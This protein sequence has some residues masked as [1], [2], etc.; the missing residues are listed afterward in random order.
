MAPLIKRNR[1]V[2]NRFEGGDGTF[3]AAS[4]CHHPRCSFQNAVNTQLPGCCCVMAPRD[5]AGFTDGNERNLAQKVD[6]R[7]W[8]ATRLQVIP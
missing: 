8:V 4:G 2:A 1:S 7:A 3:P 5:V 6:G